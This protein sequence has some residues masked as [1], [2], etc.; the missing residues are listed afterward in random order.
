MRAFF[1]TV[2]AAATPEQLTAV[3]QFVKKFTILPIRA[4]GTDNGAVTGIGNASDMSIV[5]PSSGKVLALL[6]P[7]QARTFEAKG[8]GAYNLKDFWV[9]VTID[10]DGVLVTIE[11]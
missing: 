2:A 11:D 10:G 5:L 4:D 6:A 8:S 9:D 1:K 7:L 3:D